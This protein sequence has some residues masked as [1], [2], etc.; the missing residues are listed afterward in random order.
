MPDQARAQKEA[1]LGEDNAFFYDE[2]LKCWRERGAAP[3]SLAP[4]PPPPPAAAA[5]PPGAAAAGAALPAS[6]PPP[7][8]GA[9]PQP[10]PGP[11][12]RSGVRGRYVD[13]FN[14]GGGG[15]APVS[16]GARRSPGHGGRASAV[17]ARF[18]GSRPTASA[19]DALLVHEQQGTARIVVSYS[20]VRRHARCT[21]HT[22]AHPHCPCPATPCKPAVGSCAFGGCKS[23]HY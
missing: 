23:R 19:A 4:P 14:A 9:G 7:A 22:V 3:P 13:T 2:E 5:A 15:C 20:L 17:C 21:R 16:L 18:L 1:R 8:G 6:L 11:A 12:R 10:N